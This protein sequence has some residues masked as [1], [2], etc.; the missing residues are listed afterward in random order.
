MNTPRS[1]SDLS[2]PRFASLWITSFL[3][4]T[5]NAPVSSLLAIYVEADLGRSPLFSAGLRSLLILLGGLFAV[6][7]GIV[8]ERIGTKNTYVLGSTGALVSGLMFLT[9][10]PKWLFVTCVYIGIM[11]GF[12]T[13][14][15]QAYLMQAVPRARL[16]VASAAFFLGS[17]F[18][19]ALGNQLTGLVVDRVGFRTIGVGMVAAMAIVFVGIAALMPELAERSA[20]SVRLQA[21]WDDYARLIR[22]P[23]IRLLVGI[24]YLPTCYWGAATLLIPL[25]LFRAT[26]TKASAANYAAVS[27]FVASVCQVVT[28]RLCDAFGPKKPA[29]VA[30]TGVT[31]SALCTALCARSDVGLY[32]FG[33]TGAAAAWSLS[34]TMP[35]IIHDVSG[36]GEQGRVIGMTHLAWSIGMLT[37]SLW[38]GKAVEWNPGLPFYVVTVCGLVTVVLLIALFRRGSVE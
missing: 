20:R 19:N 32:V 21:S 27:L 7:A 30:G 29:L 6:P 12:S 22:R 33:V 9:H 36:P 3:I 24:R 16:G 14:A 11:T 18:G 17:T 26:G 23:A 5:L 13:T 25:L 4:G 38:G 31:L 37:G 35:G 8:C 10:Q 1:L 34:T 15:S 28:G 2:N